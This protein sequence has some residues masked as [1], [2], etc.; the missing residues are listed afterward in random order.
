MQLLF[1]CTAHHISFC[2]ALPLVLEAII[3]C[4]VV[5]F[6]FVGAYL[7]F[8]KVVLLIL[9]HA[10]FLRVSMLPGPAFIQAD[11][12]YQKSDVDKKIWQH[13]SAWQGSAELDQAFIMGI[14]I[15][16][17]I[18]LSVRII[19]S[20]YF[21]FQVRQMCTHKKGCLATIILELAFVETWCAHMRQVSGRT[22]LSMRSTQVNC[23][24]ITEPFSVVTTRVV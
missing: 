8:L 22:V 5:P 23:T 18:L 13:L 20:L 6:N 10:T 11:L 17:S 21:Q 9:R 16:L 15:G 7:T 24:V 19:Q 2:S 12:D 1:A 3:S 14:E 4:L